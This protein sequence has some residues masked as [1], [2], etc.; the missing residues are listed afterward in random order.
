MVYKYPIKSI[1]LF[2]S[3]ASGNCNPGSDVD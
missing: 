1:I 2:G 3:R